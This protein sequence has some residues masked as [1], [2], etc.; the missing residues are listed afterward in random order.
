[1]PRRLL[2][3][4]AAAIDI[5]ERWWYLYQHAGIEVADRFN[6]A[7]DASA[8]QLLENPHIGST[9]RFQ[10]VP[11]AGARSWSVK[12]FESVLLFYRADAESV[13]IFRVLHTSQD[14]DSILGL[15]D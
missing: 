4:A 3:L 8:L 14:I 7:V 15:D 11:L 6:A 12:G 1:M 13:T 2:V 5:A 9:H 10:S